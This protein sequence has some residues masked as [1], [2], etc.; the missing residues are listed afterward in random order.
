MNEAPLHLHLSCIAQ[1]TSQLICP[2]N[3]SLSM[4]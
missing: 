3:K 2:K 1:A 4:V